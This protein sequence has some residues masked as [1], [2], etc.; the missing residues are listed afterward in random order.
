MRLATALQVLFATTAQERGRST[1]LVRGRRR[2]TAAGS[3]QAVV[4]RW[5][6]KPRATLGSLA[7]AADL[8]PPAG[9]LGVSRGRGGAR[10]LTELYAKLRGRVVLH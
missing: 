5:M 8:W 6:A 2:L 10:V 1:G 4:F 9:R 7:R 3:A